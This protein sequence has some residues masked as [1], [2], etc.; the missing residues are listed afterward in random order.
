[1]PQC[2]TCSPKM[3]DTWFMVRLRCFD[4][5]VWPCDP[6]LL[7]WSGL[8]FSSRA[9]LFCSSPRLSTQPEAKLANTSSK[10]GRRPKQQVRC[11]VRA[12]ACVCMRQERWSVEQRAGNVQ[13]T[14]IK[15]QG[16]R[17]RGWGA[18][19]VSEGLAIR[20]GGVGGGACVQCPWVRWSRGWVR[21]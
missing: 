8:S 14:G 5:L 12:R 21:V 15:I 7:G 13:H 9:A 1:M 20:Q 2:L 10:R 4:F 16:R 17:G 6:R 19:Q 3:V 18:K 11:G